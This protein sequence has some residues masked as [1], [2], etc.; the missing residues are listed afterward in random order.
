MTIIVRL[1]MVVGITVFPYA[2]PD[3]I[4]K[5]FAQYADKYTLYIAA[6]MTLL[7]IVLVGKQA[8]LSLGIVSLCTMLFARYATKLVGGLTGD[9][10]G[11][12]S[13]LAEIIVLFVF[14]F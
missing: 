13:E 1:A 6:T 7:L 4:G 14:L 12:L 11:A 5:A 8:I 10:Y 3:G 2:K 9:I